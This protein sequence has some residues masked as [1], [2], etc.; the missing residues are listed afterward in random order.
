[1]S[2]KNFAVRLAR[3]AGRIMKQKFS[4][5]IKRK[6]KKDNTPVTEADLAINKLV[7][8]AITKKFPTHSILAEEGGSINHKSEYT[9]VCDPID[10]TLPF[11]HGLPTCAF[12][13]AL[14][15]E[16]VPVLGVVYDPF[17]DRIYTAEKGKGTFLNGKKIRVSQNETLEKNLVGMSIGISGRF[18]NSLE[19]ARDLS[20][21]KAKVISLWTVVYPGS[22][23]AS[24]Q[25]I[26]TIA[27]GAPWDVAAIKILVEEAGGKVTDLD[28]NDQ[29]YDREIK[30]CILTN[31]KVHNKIL[32]IIKKNESLH[33]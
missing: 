10:G 4:V 19:A 27:K 26:A 6:Y 16:G 14:V 18:F 29:R 33:S 12:S 20:N 23:V 30:G 13:L 25:F 9:W 32:E 1:M 7:I 22:L 11:S 5:S 24:G 3:K 17:L 21:Q 28:G 31:G 2:Y 15:K 8:E